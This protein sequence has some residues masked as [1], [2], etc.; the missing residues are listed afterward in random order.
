MCKLYIASEAFYNLQTNGQDT[1]L[2]T[3]ELIMRFAAGI[4]NM[5]IYESYQKNNCSFVAHATYI[6][7][8]MHIQQYIIQHGSV[9]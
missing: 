2:F 3:R 5:P 6:K 4:S 8:K 1:L 7:N 9:V